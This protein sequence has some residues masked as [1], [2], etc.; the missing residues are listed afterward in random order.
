MGLSSEV[1]L[2]WS[3]AQGFRFNEYYKFLLDD[4]RSLDHCMSN[5]SRF[6]LVWTFS[7]NIMHADRAFSAAIC[8]RHKDE[9]YMMFRENVPTKKSPDI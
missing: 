8:T 4:S 9:L 1:N 7:R 3:K 6:F 5:M 2:I